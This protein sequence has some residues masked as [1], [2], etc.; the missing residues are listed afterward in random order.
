MKGQ[1]SV[2]N[3]CGKEFVKKMNTQVNCSAQC[4]TKSSL[5][6]MVERGNVNKFKIMARDGFKCFYCGKS[7]YEHQARLVLDHL[8]PLAKGGKTDND[9]LVT[10]CTECNCSKSSMMIDEKLLS[11]MQAEVKRR[12]NQL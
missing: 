11:L 5:I 12:N 1:K 7:T 3:V 10:C 9:N 4:T 8:I 6:K 2:C